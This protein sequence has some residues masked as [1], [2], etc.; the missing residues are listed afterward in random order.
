MQ[1]VHL[2]RIKTVATQVGETI[3]LNMP[4][5][6]TPART[7]QFIA[8]LVHA[9]Q[10]EAQEPEWGADRV[11]VVITA[12]EVRILLCIEWLCDAIWLEPAGG[13]NNSPEYLWDWLQAK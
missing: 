11:Q 3:T 12:D 13:L 6:A 2:S 8:Q 10:A 4:L 1:Q 7:N 9:L 5:P